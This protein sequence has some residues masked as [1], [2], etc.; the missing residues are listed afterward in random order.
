MSIV[1]FS[2][3]GDAAG[4]PI[5][6]ARTPL[7]RASSRWLPGLLLLAFCLAACAPV[8]PAALSPRMTPTSGGVLPT[9]LAFSPT[10]VQPVGPSGSWTLLFHDEFSGSALDT[11]K[12][13]TCFFNFRVGA[14]D[15]TH[16]QS[17]QEVYQPT[18]VSV[19]QGILRLTAK[20]QTVRVAGHA[21][22][23]TSGMISSGPACDG[24]A[25]RLTFT[26][27]YV[28]MRAWVPVGQGL[29]PAFWALPADESWPPELDIFE[30]LGQ[31]PHEVNLH[32][33]AA[34]GS[35][36]G[37]AWDGPNFAA[38]WHTYAVDWEPGSITWYVDG[39]LR[40][41][42]RAGPS[43]VSR[44]LYLLANLAVGGDWPGP[45]AATTPFPAVFAIDYIRVWHRRA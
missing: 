22:G 42:D 36:D 28:E 27:G 8:A 10:G 44:P 43:I 45:P 17:E 2:R 25:D 38:G 30:L 12:W 9:I 1:A 32:Y 6:E 39:T 14:Q 16:D 24:C 23:Y 15:C 35:D 29:W 11:K 18:N 40:F 34:N 4:T 26:Y 33:H 20:K 19:G 7:F 31:R 5:P 3:K 41:R 21:F 13:T 37:T